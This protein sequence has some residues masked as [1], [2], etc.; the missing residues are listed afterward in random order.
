M[1]LPDLGRVKLSQGFLLIIIKESLNF[2]L[3]PVPEF[4]EVFVLQQLLCSWSLLRVQTQTITRE[5]N[6]CTFVK[7]A[8]TVLQREALALID[9]H[10]RKLYALE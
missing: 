1:F 10:L 5:C 7:T 6:S 9:L 8:Q 3:K 4:I 2:V